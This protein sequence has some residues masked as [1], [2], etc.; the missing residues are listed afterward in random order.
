MNSSKLAF[1]TALWLW[2]LVP[3]CWVVAQDCFLACPAGVPEYRF[4]PTATSWEAHRVLAKQMGCE[5]ASISSEAEQ[6]AAVKA[7]EPYIGYPY[8]AQD[9][10]ESSFAFLGGR[11]MMDSSS[12]DPD[13]GTYT[14]EWVDG[15]GTLDIQRG[16]NQAEH[17][18]KFIPGDPNGG[19]EPFGNEP[20]LALSL[21]ENGSTGI[22]RG[23]WVDFGN[24]NSPALYKCCAPSQ[25]SSF[26]GDKK[27]FFSP[28][29][30]LWEDHQL[31]AREVG[32]ELASIQG[33]EEQV[34]AEIAMEPYI[35]FPYKG[36]ENFAS[37][38]VYMGGKLVRDQSNPYAGDYTFEW[39]DGSS[40]LAVSRGFNR[41]FA[42]YSNFIPGD[43]NGGTSG[44]EMEQYLALSLDENQ[45][46]NIRRGKWVDFGSALSPALYQCRCRPIQPPNP[47]NN[48]KE[49]TDAPYVNSQDC[50]NNFIKPLATQIDF[51]DEKAAVVDLPVPFLFKG[52]EP[53]TSIAVTV[54]GTVHLNGSLES[55]FGTVP[56]ATGDD[57][58]ASIPRIQVAQG[59]I[60]ETI[61]RD[62]FI[63]LC[64]SIEV[65]DRR[66]FGEDVFMII[67][68][69]PG[70]P[71]AGIELL[72]YYNGDIEMRYEAL[73]NPDAADFPIVAGIEDGQG[74][75]LPARGGGFAEDGSSLTSLV[76][77]RCQRFS[78]PAATAA[79]VAPTP[80]P[81]TSPT[82]S[83]TA[84]RGPSPAPTQ[85]PVPSSGCTTAFRFVDEIENTRPIIVNAGRQIPGNTTTA[86]V[87]LHR[88]FWFK[89]TDPITSLVVTVHGSIHLDGS[90]ETPFATVPI[91]TDGEGYEKVARIQVVQ[92]PLSS[93]G[94][95]SG[96][97]FCS[98]VY[99]GETESSTIITWQYYG[100]TLLYAQAELYNDGTV[101]MRWSDRFDRSDDDDLMISVGIE[102][103]EGLA[104]PA[105]GIPFQELGGLVRYASLKNN[106]RVF[107]VDG[108]GGYF[109]EEP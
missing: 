93:T 6:A 66:Q 36:T 76:A 7:M 48:D 57:G 102:D 32:C 73:R 109:F 10:F 104:V 50:D 69:F 3:T 23:A 55:F 17:F 94:C 82:E 80:A 40:D 25:S 51:G 21:D 68:N 53:I 18:S 108:N 103:G 33:A 20:Y 74:F 54:Y 46:R 5:L 16:V 12:K 1:L 62:F 58:Y 84:P 107:S 64:S 47:C 44:F 38:F 99:F 2:L 70:D 89:G 28:V 106:C 19:T 4:N 83:P 95:A 30:A 59:A 8:H 105:T 61:C 13:A 56:I 96:I 85:V 67:W 97:R 100:T 98:A 11:V 26:C 75:A 90:T 35:G 52:T 78:A 24:F 77:G 31:F 72:L 15:S 87:E 43:P 39:V 101:E 14:Y 88:P 86:T 34:A 27:F 49:E 79:P 45:S 9:F 29:E 41:Q 71:V 92:G 91:A 60:D 65:A 63:G 37:S 42:P 81:T 22:P